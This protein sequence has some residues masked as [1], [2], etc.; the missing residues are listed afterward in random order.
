ML[1]VILGIILSVEVPKEQPKFS[2][3]SAVAGYFSGIHQWCSGEA[4]GY[5]SVRGRKWGLSE[6]CKTLRNYRNTKPYSRTQI[7]ATF[8]CQCLKFTSKPLV[9][10]WFHSVCLV[11]LTRLAFTMICSGWYCPHCHNP[12]DVGQ[13]AGVD[14]STLTHT[15]G[16]SQNVLIC[17]TCSFGVTGWL[18]LSC[19]VWKLYPERATTGD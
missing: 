8:W 16:C 4:L 19:S 18:P 14:S 3:I 7:D 12:A 6:K 17:A 15:T 11:V 10:F 13:G 5:Y 9:M 2:Y 1:W